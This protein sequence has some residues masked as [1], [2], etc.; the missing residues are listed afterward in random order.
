MERAFSLAVV[1]HRLS[2]PYA[3][4][5]SG[6]NRFAAKSRPLTQW[7]PMP[8]DGPQ[9]RGGAMRALASGQTGLVGASAV[10]D[11]GRLDGH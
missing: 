4:E 5:G 10:R 9:H 6:R 1:S 11:P 2:L 7:Q 8:D 3:G